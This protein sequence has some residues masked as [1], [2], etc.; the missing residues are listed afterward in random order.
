MSK[1]LENIADVFITLSIVLVFTCLLVFFVIGLDTWSSRKI[2]NNNPSEYCILDRDN[3]RLCIPKDVLR[4]YI[5][6]HEFFKGCR[7]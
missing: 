5:L 7:K 2:V 6:S 4:E 3:N 1:I